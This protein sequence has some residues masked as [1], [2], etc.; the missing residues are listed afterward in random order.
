[1][2]AHFFMRLRPGRDLMGRRLPRRTDPFAGKHPAK[3]RG[4][5]DHRTIWSVAWPPAIH[6]GSRYSDFSIFAGPSV[7]RGAW[8]RLCLVSFAYRAFLDEVE[9]T[10]E[11]YLAAEREAKEARRGL[12]QGD[13]IPQNGWRRGTR[14]EGCK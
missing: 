4:G 1:M 7:R 13:F 12:W 5:V 11:A 6:L 3:T 8:L 10:K 14:I 9:G 2:T